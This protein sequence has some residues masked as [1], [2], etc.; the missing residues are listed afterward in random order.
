M[1]DNS[2]LN[3]LAEIIGMKAAKTAL[4]TLY[5]IADRH[6]G[7]HPN[8]RAVL[9]FEPNTEAKWAKAITRDRIDETEE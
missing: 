2:P 4:E 3:D 6:R 5:V 9:Y 7:E 8:A 1:Q